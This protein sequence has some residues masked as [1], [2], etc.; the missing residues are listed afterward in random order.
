MTTMLWYIFP[1]HEVVLSIL[2]ELKNV[3]NLSP[4]CCF[5]YYDCHEITSKFNR[6]FPMNFH[7]EK[8]KFMRR[9]KTFKNNNENASGFS[10]NHQSLYLLHHIVII[11]NSN[12]TAGI[13]ARLNWV[14]KIENFLR[15]SIPVS[16][17]FTLSMLGWKCFY[18][19]RCDGEEVWGKENVGEFSERIGCINYAIFIFVHGLARQQT[20]TTSGEFRRRER[21][22]NFKLCA[23]CIFVL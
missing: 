7:L 14:I 20:S 2:L 9:I 21:E 5:C 18:M 12:S 1:M 13:E 19:W 17:S 8:L 15:F 22:I 23:A 16:H 4:V 10:L 11:I 6:K 3:I